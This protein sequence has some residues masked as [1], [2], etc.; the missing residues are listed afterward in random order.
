MKEEDLIV[1]KLFL[2]SGVKRKLF[3][4]QKQMCSCLPPSP[5]RERGHNLVMFS[6]D[7]WPHVASQVSL[8]HILYI[9]SPAYINH[10]PTQPTKHM[11]SYRAEGG[12][13]SD[14]KNRM[15]DKIYL[16]RCLHSQ[17]C[18]L[19]NIKS[20]SCHNLTVLI[21]QAIFPFFSRFLILHCKTL[22]L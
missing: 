5:Q 12:E 18:W 2:I 10:Q 8:H 20:Q 4:L 6:Q 13:Y 3:P 14:E 9:Y 19:Q 1:M 17:Q 7:T 15:L 11:F 22:R 16:F 21:H